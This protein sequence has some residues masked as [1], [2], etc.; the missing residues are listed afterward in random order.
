[1]AYTKANWESCDDDRALSFVL[2]QLKDPE[3]FLRKVKE[4]YAAPEAVSY[5]ELRF[6]DGRIFE[7]YSQPQRIG[8]RVVGRVWSFRDV[9]DRKR[10]EQ[11][12][13]KRIKEL[14]EFYSIAVG[15]ELRMKGLKEEIEELKGQLEKYKKP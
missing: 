6:K 2:D 3:G 12:V 15:R 11:E 5:D 8:Q 9:T 1:V 7:R 4:L 10:A 14:E 13:K